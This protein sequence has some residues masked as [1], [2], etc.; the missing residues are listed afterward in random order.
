MKAGLVATLTPIVVLGV[1]AQPARADSPAP[2]ITS[3]EGDPGRLGDPASW[4]TPEFNR[5]AG[6]V[7]MGAEFAYAAGY[8]GTGMNVGVVDSGVFA[9]HV[10]EHGSLATN[11]AIGDRYLSVETQ[12]GETGPTSGFYDPAFNDSHGTHV[13]GTI[14]ASRDGVGET[15]PSGPAANMHGVAFN[16]NVY[17]GNTHKTDGVL[18]G[19]LPATATAAQRPDDA[20]LANVYRAVNAAQTANGKPIRIITSSWGSQPNTENYNTYD[21][22][23][24]SPAGFG[25]NTAWRLWSTPDGVVDANGATVRWL[26]GALDTARTG[27]VIQFTAGNSG[28]VNPSPRGAA[29]YFLPDLEGRWYTTSGINPSLGRTFNPDGSVL[30]PGQQAFNQCGVAKWSCVTAPSNGINSTTVS[31]VNGVP[32]A[33]YGSSS[34]TSMAG[35]HSAAALSL[36]MQRFPYM[37]NE[38]A[39]YTMFTTGRQN[40]TINDAAGIAVQNPTRGQ[41]VQVPDNRNGWHTVSLREAMK[42]PGQLLG[43]FVADLRGQ[44]DVWSNDISDVAIRARQQEDAAEAAAWEATK[45]AKGW[46]QGLPADASD[47]D[48]SD[49]AIGTR[50]EQARTARAYEGSLTKQGDGTLF[51]TGSN[52]WHGTSTVQAGKLSIAGAHTSSIDVRGGTLGG[53]GSV[54]DSVTVTSGVL[55]P[56]LSSEEA[57]HITDV[58][59]TAGKILNV[60]G[61]V[62]IGREGRLAVTISGDHDYT[63]VRAAGQLALAGELDLDV[64]GSLTPGTVLTIMSG[65]SVSGSF[66]AL[67]ENRVLNAGGRLF[68]VS[69][70][71]N[72]V[73]LTVLRALPQEK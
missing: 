30:V 61:N 25:L 73:T 16:S 44:N 31:V 20:Y 11:Y 65:S 21:A 47:V 43:P 17:M 51:L 28:Y 36:I 63:S 64:R 69:Y 24:G 22:P 35:P 56:G 4:R 52:T 48:K 41:I 14:G 38:Q 6:L 10:R 45:V 32:Q 58:P 26:N 40:N 59:A 49:F 3:Y 55:Q 8:S 18:Y 46:T 71:N 57:E 1:V 15:Q 70:Q 54:G 13:T 27:T 60:G 50:R 53:S 34:G 39:L 72:S 12:G 67:P 2:P 37:T 42:G 23:P 7:S 5:D 19:L 66:H 29:P 68:R 62:N 9:G 33:R